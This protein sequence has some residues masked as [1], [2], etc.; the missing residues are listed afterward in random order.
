MIKH[1]EMTPTN[2]NAPAAPAEPTP[3]P[4]AVPKAQQSISVATAVEPDKSSSS[5]VTAP[6]VQ[7]I[8]PPKAAGGNLITQES[9]GQTSVALPLQ[10]SQNAPQVITPISTLKTS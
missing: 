1:D 9:K 6:P 8:A 10:Q 5:I 2:I 7:D 3:E 4:L